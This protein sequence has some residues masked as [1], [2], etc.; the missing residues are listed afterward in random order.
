MYGNI[1]LEHL[2]ILFDVKVEKCDHDDKSTGILN[3]FYLRYWKD[4]ENLKVEAVWKLKVEEK[5]W[6]IY[7]SFISFRR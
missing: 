4:N 1:L 6:K 2:S 5:L 7:E 3:E